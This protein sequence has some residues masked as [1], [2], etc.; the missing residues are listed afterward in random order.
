MGRYLGPKDKKSRRAG[1]KL[2]L[3]GERDASPK[4]G[5]VRRPYP[6]GVHGQ[7][8]TRR[9]VSEYGTQLLEK[10]KVRW[11]YGILERQFKKYF[12]E[13]QREPGVAT[14]LLVEKLERRLDN[15]VYRLGM[16]SSRNAA[17]QLV[18]HGHIAV[19]GHKVTIPSFRVP[20]GV[21][22][23]IRESSRSKGVARDL[24]ARLKKYEPPRWLSLDKERL[25][26]KIQA[27][28]AKD[29]AAIP[30]DIQKII[31]FYSR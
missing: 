6:P 4:S 8:R 27:K 28:P 17:R 2:F 9:S 22:V 31:E 30:A 1:T 3:K 23:A 18:T 15:V 14:D 5:A 26:G 7:K 10:Q 24:A 29:D 11:S 19:N 13:A 16:A 12:R 21:A 20:L 25:E